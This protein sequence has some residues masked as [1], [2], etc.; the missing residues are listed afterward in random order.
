[1]RGSRG[2]LTFASVAEDGRAPRGGP[3]ARGPRGGPEARGPKGG[4]DARGPR[5]GPEARGPKGGPEARGPKV[6]LVFLVKS[7]MRVSIVSP[8]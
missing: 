2:R 3:E 7:P 8:H 1:M 5:G 4:P 6:F